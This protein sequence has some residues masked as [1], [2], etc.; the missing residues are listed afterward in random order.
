M[1]PLNYRQPRQVRPQNRAVDAHAHAL[2]GA[3]NVDQPRG[4]ELFQVMRQRRGTHLMRIE[5]GGAGECILGRPDLL[6]DLIA[7]R[8][9]ERARN[10]RELLVVARDSPFSR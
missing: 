1:A 7:A 4:L 3:R 6:E 10:V 5:E 8:L 9:G 2:A